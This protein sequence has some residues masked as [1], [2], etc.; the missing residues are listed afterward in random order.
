MTHKTE[1]IINGKYWENFNYS[2]W[3][4]GFFFYPIPTNYKIFTKTF[5]YNFTSAHDG[6]QRNI[7]H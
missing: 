7:M 1:C 6:I 3:R 2:F 5:Y 4:K